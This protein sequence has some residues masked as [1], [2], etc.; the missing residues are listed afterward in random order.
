MKIIGIVGRA[1]YNKDNQKIIQINEDIRKFFAEED[2]VTVALLPPQNRYYVETKM[3]MDQL[4]E[5]DRKKLDSLLDLCDGFII[6]GG[7][8]WYQFDEY[9]IEHAIK[10][11]KPLLAICLGFQA[12]CSMFAKERT[13]FDM[14][15]RITNE[16]HYGDS[17]KYIHN[18]KINENT[19]LQDILQETEIKVNSVHHDIVNFELKNLKISAL[20]PDN[21]VEAVELPEKKFILGVQWHPEYLVDEN[22]R[23]I[24]QAF[25]NKL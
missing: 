10:K 24:R 21:I 25:I 2:V 22:S 6:P 11:D 23:K 5:I 15:T 3:G 4:T 13:K 19:L 7:T 14:T 9:V 17:S 12:L 20:S 8:Y 16:D 18:I 1:F